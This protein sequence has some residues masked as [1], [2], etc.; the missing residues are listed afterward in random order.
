MDDP[1][2]KSE[3]LAQAISEAEAI[4]ERL[5]RE[6]DEARSRLAWLLG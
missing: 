2:N 3:R 4:L 1:T 5:V 6:Q